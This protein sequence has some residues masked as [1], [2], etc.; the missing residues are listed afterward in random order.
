MLVGNYQLEKKKAEWLKMQ[1]EKT[2]K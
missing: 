2:G 1:K